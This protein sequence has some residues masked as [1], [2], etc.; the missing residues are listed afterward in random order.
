MNA[1]SRIIGCLQLSG[2]R[3]TAKE[4]KDRTRLWWPYRALLELEEEGVIHS[5]WIEGPYP[6][7]RVYWIEN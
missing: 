2:L 5:D 7:K 6:R 1:K 3:L 4:I